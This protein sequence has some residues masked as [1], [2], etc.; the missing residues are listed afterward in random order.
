MQAKMPKF[1]NKQVSSYNSVSNKLGNSLKKQ[2]PQQP[3]TVTAT[4]MTDSTTG[5]LHRQM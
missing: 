4:S 3:R 1:V 2:L 5:N